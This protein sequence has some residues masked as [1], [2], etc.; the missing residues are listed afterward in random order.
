MAASRQEVYFIA[1]RMQTGSIRRELGLIGLGERANRL[2]LEVLEQVDAQVR[3]WGIDRLV[4]E[5]QLQELLGS[6]MKLPGNLRTLKEA[7]HEEALTLE[8]F[9][10]WGI[11]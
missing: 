6:L 5:A 10:E 11:R 2:A 3:Q 4:A 1:I 7:G 8:T 9:E